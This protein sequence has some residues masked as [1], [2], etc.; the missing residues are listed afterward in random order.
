MEAKPTLEEIWRA[1]LGELELSLSQANFKTWFR[2]TTILAREKDAV[3]IGVPTAFIREWL[4]NKY[5]NQ[6]LAALQRVD[7]SIRRVQYTIKTKPEAPRRL[8][9]TTR[10]VIEKRRVSSPFPS[11]RRGQEHFAMSLNPKYTFSTFVVGANNELAAAAAKAVARNPGRVYNP[12]F[13]YGGVGLGKTHL[14]QAIGNAILS[15]HPAKM[16]VY[17]TSEMFTHA[18]VTSL[19][20]QRIEEFKQRFRSMDVLLL[21]DVQFLAGKEK[22]QEEFF[23]TFNVLYSVNK[24]IVLTSDRPPKEITTLEERLRSRFEGGML[25]DISSPDME[26]RVAILSAKCKDKGVQVPED[27]LYFIASSASR[28]IREL[29][30][31]LNRLLAT[32]ALKNLRPTLPVAKQVLQN[33]LAQPRRRILHSRQVLEV[34]SRFYNVKE[35]DLTG[36]CRKREIVRP[37]QI[38]MYLLRQEN[39]CSYPTIG[40]ILGGRDHTTVMHACEKISKAIQRDE[41][42]RQELHLIQERLRAEMVAAAH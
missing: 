30:G 27:V 35:E 26:T 4:R 22:T 10:I 34:V 7:Q 41:T 37:R 9:P 24:Q 12:L 32:C 20:E 11:A 1:V 28:N 25:A 21:D 2:D 5:H 13:I 31:L 42:L 18:L 23:H 14:L 33:L 8:N 3:T 40:E 36:T 17:V 39:R 15:T 19:R 38:A 16:V 6:I 29:E